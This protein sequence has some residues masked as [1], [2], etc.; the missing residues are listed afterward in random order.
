MNDTFTD[1]R[2]RFEDMEGKYQSMFYYAPIP[3]ITLNQNGIIQTMN[4]KAVE[5]LGVVR[6]DK[7][8]VT[9]L[10]K[11]SHDVFFSHLRSVQ[12]SA[13]PA[14][15]IVKLADRNGH[16][17]GVKLSSTAVPGDKSRFLTAVINVDEV[18]KKEEVIH[19]MAYT[20]SLTGLPNRVMFQERVKSCIK[21]ASR[22]RQNM[23]I[24]FIDLDN[25]K[26]INDLQG[27]E[28][29]DFVLKLVG[30]RMAKLQSDSDMLARIGGDEFVFLLRHA[31]DDEKTAQMARKILSSVA[32]PIQINGIAYSLS[33][34]M[35]IAMF[36][37]DGCNVGDLLKSA[38]TAMYKA[39]NMGKNT[40]S[41]FNYSMKEEIFVKA[42]KERNLK[43]ALKWQEFYLDYQPQVD[44]KS[45]K[46][47][48]LEALL[49]WKSKTLGL[50]KPSEFIPLAEELSLIY[51]L[52][53][54]VLQQVCLRVKDWQRRGLGCI[55][56]AVNLSPMQMRNPYF[57]AEVKQLIQEAEIDPECLAFE[58][59]E[60]T[61]ITDFDEVVKK[62]NE[63]RTFGIT[64]CL[65]DFGTGY[66]SLNYLKS[67]PIE[68]LK[69]DKSFI[70]NLHH[71]DAA[72]YLLEGILS[73]SHKLGLKVIAEGV[74]EH[75]QLEILETLGCDM[76]QGYCK[77]RPLSEA[78]IENIFDLS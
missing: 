14:E 69:I 64:I 5:L 75:E 2:Q 4:L 12:E 74:E 73:L 27:H 47:Q 17:L 44:L 32:A 52:G 43:E 18:K 42:E 21:Y 24:F 13:K 39:K 26:Q 16:V 3:Y 31:Y 63:L 41:F 11:E 28:T 15:C 20:D 37:R 59:T 60:N 45:G 25:F 46:I 78:E 70:D 34:S 7:P 33:A 62:L 68:V 8:F 1:Y 77:F 58:I 38:D 65:D 35:G 6:P 40:F 22:S 55:P 36:P 51:P 9:C 72:Y 48:G 29:G 54:W 23:A 50:I 49:R 67:L 76:I 57:V 19:K 56:V 30:K 53:S 61:L 10:H 71:Q 66:S